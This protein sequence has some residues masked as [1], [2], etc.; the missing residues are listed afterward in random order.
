MGV[1]LRFNGGDMRFFKNGELQ[2]EMIISALKLAANDYE[3]G[4]LIE[5]RDTLLEIVNAIDEFV[6]QN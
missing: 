6:E 2:D 5:V 4:E 1:N 3:C